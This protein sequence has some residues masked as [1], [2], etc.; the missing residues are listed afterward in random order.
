MMTITV[1]MTTMTTTYSGDDDDDDDVDD[2]DNSGDD[3]DDD[4]DMKTE[5]I[6]KSLFGHNLV[7]N[8][9]IYFNVPLRSLRFPVTFIGSR[10][11]VKVKDRNGRRQLFMWLIFAARC[12]A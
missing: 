5:K 8:G 12:D 2:D 11:K 7:A 1:V 6:P 3:D 9:S 4:D 10:S